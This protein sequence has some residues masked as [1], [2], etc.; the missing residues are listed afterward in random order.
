MVNIFDFADGEPS[1]VYLETDTTIQEV[2]NAEEVQTYVEGFGRVRDGAL[3]PGNTTTYLRH[4]AE[5]LE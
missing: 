1:V 2:S 5:Q 3:E 4:L